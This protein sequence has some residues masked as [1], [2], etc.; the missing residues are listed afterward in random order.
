MVIMGG[1]RLVIASM[2]ALVLAA[3]GLG[4][5][6]DT[7]S[8]P[9]TPVHECLGVTATIVGTAKTDSLRGTDGADVIWAGPGYDKVVAFGGNDL[10]CMGAANDP[11]EARPDRIGDFGLWN[12][13]VLGGPGDDRIVG[14]PGGNS[15]DGEAGDD[16]IWMAPDP[17]L[18]DYLV[19]EGNY[20]EG[21]PGNDVIH[22]R[23]GRDKLWGDAGDDMLDGSNGDDIMSGGFGADTLIGGDGADD[24]VGRGGADRLDGG[25]GNDRLRGDHTDP[26]SNR[27]AGV[28]VLSGGPGDDVLDGGPGND[29][30][31]AGPDEDLCTS[32]FEG[33]QASGCEQELTWSSRGWRQGVAGV[34]P[35]G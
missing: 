33:S 3:C 29:F 1:N 28:D 12:E 7:A 25:L 13:I 16:E 32:P 20:G 8:P 17:S 5:T 30:A 11:L 2:L 23:A 6:K 14:G 35:P 15:L 10:I 34:A 31:D 22:G 18:G 4:A 9:R 26:G 21:G 19:Y 27:Y 24:L